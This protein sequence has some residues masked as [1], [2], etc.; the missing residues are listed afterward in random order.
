LPRPRAENVE[1]VGEPRSQIRST[2]AASTQGP[3]LS[4][5]KIN[6]KSKKN[7]INYNYIAH[8]KTKFFLN[9]NMDADCRY[10]IQSSRISKGTTVQT[11]ENDTCSN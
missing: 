11:F 8:L 2:L 7:P 4:P 9:K 6:Y 10:Y 5:L 1:V 3:I